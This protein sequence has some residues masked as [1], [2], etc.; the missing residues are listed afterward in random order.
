MG[1]FPLLVLTQNGTRRDVVEEAIVGL[2]PPGEEPKAELLALTYG[3][4]SLMFENEDDQEWLIWRFA[5]LD[6]ILRET[7]AF[8]EMAREGH[9]QGLK[10]G[11][12][13]GLKGATKR[14]TRSVTSDTSAD[15]TC[16]FS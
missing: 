7:R 14:E 5:M 11:L 13:E 10:E 2:T 12:K 15:C 8:Q 1:L 3:L 9:E 4:A 16:T 6:D